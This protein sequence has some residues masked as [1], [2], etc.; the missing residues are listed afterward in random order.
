MC[1]GRRDVRIHCIFCANFFFVNLDCS[2]MVCLK[3]VKLK[4]QPKS[5]IFLLIHVYGSTEFLQFTACHF[6]CLPSS[7]EMF[8]TYTMQCILTSSSFA[9]PFPRPQTWSVKGPSS[10]CVPMLSWSL[11]PCQ[12]TLS[13]EQSRPRGVLVFIFTCHF[14]AHL[15]KQGLF[16]ENFVAVIDNLTYCMPPAHSQTQ[17]TKIKQKTQN[18]Q[19]ELSGTP[20]PS[21]P[22]S[23]PWLEPAASLFCISETSGLRWHSLYISP[24]PTKRTLGL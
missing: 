2:K 5:P 19:R 22:R 12:S 6:L 14:L 23:V 1:Q 8:P 18:W 15:S 3:Q 11:P 4:L 13:L 24:P 21:L 10:S 20:S 9:H 7:L 16:L 17:K